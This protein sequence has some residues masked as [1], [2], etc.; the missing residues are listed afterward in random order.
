M[1][2]KKENSRVIK[3]AE[4]KKRIYES[5]LELFKRDGFGTSVDSIVEMAGVSKG[6]FYVHYESKH[7]LIIDYINTIDL[8]YEDYFSSLPSDTKP[9]VMLILV[10]EKI[11]D[12]IINNIGFDL[13]KLI[14]EALITKTINTDTQ[15]SYDRKVYQIY[16]QIIKLGV[17]QGEFKATLNIDSVSKHC[18]MSIR[19]M[20]YEWC[21]RF[22]DF[23]LKNEII[24]H[25]DLL[26]SGIKNNDGL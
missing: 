12:V 17:Q 16:N 5:A 13:I 9:S 24:R 7:S 8:G 10:T 15:L 26:L 19:G 6:A 11:T 20:T 21:I 23:D 4:T 18:I 1:V 25:F 14:Y 22:P 3:A 2:A